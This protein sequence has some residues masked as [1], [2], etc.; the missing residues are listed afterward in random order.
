MTVPRSRKQSKA[1]IK[2]MKTTD[3][4]LCA[5]CPIDETSDQF[6]EGTP[7]FKVLK[8]IFPYSLWDGQD[9]ID[10]LMV[11]PLSHTDTISSFSD[12]EKI[13]YVNI[14]Q[15]YEMQGYNV[16]ARAPVSAIKTIVHQ[17]THLIK[18]HGQAK[19]FVLSIRKPLIRIIR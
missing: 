1:Y 14:L 8:N 16:Y 13:D 17:H 3:S 9:V 12:A 19:R 5:F 6:V 15:K 4:S 10:H 18:T 11:V 7:Y 2:H